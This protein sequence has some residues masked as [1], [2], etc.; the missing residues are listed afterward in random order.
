MRTV[1]GQ[2]LLLVAAGLCVTGG[3]RAWSAG[4]DGLATS[5]WSVG[6]FLLGMW[7]AMEVVRWWEGKSKGE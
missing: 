7:A 1:G 3:I 4:M 6:M 5:A 2:P